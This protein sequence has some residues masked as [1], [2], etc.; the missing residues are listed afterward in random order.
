[1]TPCSLREWISQKCLKFAT[2]Q[3]AGRLCKDHT[4]KWGK[5]APLGGRSVPSCPIDFNIAKNFD[6]CSSESGFHRN[7]KF[8]TFEEAGR[9]CKT[10]PQ[11]GVKV[12]PLGGRRVLK[13][14]PLTFNGV[15]RP[16]KCPIE[17]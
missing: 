16:M 14:A 6:A 13:F 2:F 10:I 12:A 17:T 3:E 8:A 5:V 7:V 1:M 4:S 15:G 9:L 11:N